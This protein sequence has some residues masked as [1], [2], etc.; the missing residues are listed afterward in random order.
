MSEKNQKTSNSK[1][2][3]KAVNPDQFSITYN[4]ACPGY[5]E[6][7]AGESIKLDMANERVK[8]WLANNIIVK[9]N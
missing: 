2:K 1:P 4:E 8:K 3:Y 7:S 6:L 9:E 5:A